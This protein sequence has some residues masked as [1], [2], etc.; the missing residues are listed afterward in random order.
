MADALFELS[1]P[2]EFEFSL[3]PA[4]ELALKRDPLSF[5]G[6]A[7]L[8]SGNNEWKLSFTRRNFKSVPGGGVEFKGAVLRFQDF[9]LSIAEELGLELFIRFENVGTVQGPLVVEI[10]IPGE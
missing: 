1:I 6:G 9:S 4:D 10:D 3:K 2:Y 5:V 7:T 8:F